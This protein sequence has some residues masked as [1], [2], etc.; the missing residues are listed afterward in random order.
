MSGI[1]RTSGGNLGPVTGPATT[2]P[3]TTGAATPSSTATSATTSRLSSTGGAA[4]VWATI[5]TAGTRPVP[6]GVNLDASGGRRPV[7]LG[8]NGRFTATPGRDA[9][10]PAAAGNGLFAAASLID[11]SK[12]NL[13]D[14]IRMAP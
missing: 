7:A 11:D 3:A 1:G 14:A 5:A 4:E 8:Q 10:T 9:T 12:D 2:E 13:F 6:A